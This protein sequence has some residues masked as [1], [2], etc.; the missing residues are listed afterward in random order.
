M[1][2]FIKPALFVIILATPFVGKA[3][4]TTDQSGPFILVSTAYAPDT[5]DQDAAK[6][7]NA[8]NDL[9]KIA[10]GGGGDPAIGAMKSAW[11]DM[12]DNWFQQKAQDRDMVQQMQQ[13]EKAAEQAAAQA[14]QQQKL[15]DL[16]EAEYNDLQ[17]SL[18]KQDAAD[19]QAAQDA[20]D[21]AGNKAMQEAADE[22]AAADAAQ[23]AAD[24][25]ATADEEA[26]AQADDSDS[27]DWYGDSG[28]NWES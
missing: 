28:D 15:D 8:V 7:I 10:K 3:Q 11:V 17:D 6:V 19:A 21:A 12:V 5:S 26:T 25:Q 22:Q 1:N 20:Q 18:A 14:E 13:D 16:D 2:K 23:A 9:L 27:Y 4:S 24:A